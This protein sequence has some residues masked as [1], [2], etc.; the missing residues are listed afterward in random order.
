MP[1]SECRGTGF[2]RVIINDY[3]DDEGNVK[4][5][6]REVWQTCEKCGG[7]G[8]ITGGEYGRTTG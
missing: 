4:E 6:K 1:C 8:N 2:L 7:S 5:C 3:Y